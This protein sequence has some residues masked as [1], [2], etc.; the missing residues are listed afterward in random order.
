MLFVKIC[1]VRTVED[2]Q[3]AAD[4]G[5]NAIGLNFVPASPRFVDEDTARAIASAIHGRPDVELV[6]VVANLS[7]AEARSLRARVSL[8]RL[9]LH[10][11]E[12]EGLVAALQPFAFKAVRIGSADDVVR[13]RRYPSDPLLVDARHGD[14]LGGTGR[15][16]DWSL[17][18]ELAR[19]RPI[20]IAGGLRP[21]NVADAIRAVRPFGVD[22]ASGVEIR[23]GVQSPDRIRAF[24]AAATRA[25]SRR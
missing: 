6:G 23:P 4:A 2:A 12:P 5:A 20:L 13:A 16:F 25:S 8:D 14:A 22:V 9:Q 7:E 10:G 24:V 11:D 1:G 17:V 3:V 21:E 19:E 15:S 18:E